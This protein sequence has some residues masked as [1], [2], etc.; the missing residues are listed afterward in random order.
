M[1]PK[2]GRPA[3]GALASYSSEIR[4]KIY[5]LRHNNSGWGAITIL[6]ELEHVLHYPSQQ[7]P[8]VDSVHRYLKECGFV[9]PKTP[10]SD[11][12]EVSIPPV[13]S[14]HDLW[15]MDAQGAVFVK[16]V[17]YVSMINIKDSKSKAYIMSFPVQ[18]KSKMSQPKTAHY[19]WTLRLA[20]E[21]FGLPKAM[22]V[23]KDS[24]FKDN[25]SKSPFPSVV[26]L[27][28][29]GLGIELS[30]INVAPPAKQAMVER[31]HQTLDKQVFQGKTYK[32]WHELFLNT[33]KRRFILNEKYP[34]RS[35]GKRAPF[36]VYPDVLNTQRPY[37]VEQEK[38]LLNLDLVEKHLEQYT[39]Y[40]K[41]S[42]VRT[43]SLKGIYYL[44][45]AEPKN[46]VQIKFYAISK[47]L[48]FR[49]VNEQILKE[50]ITENFAKN[51]LQSQSTSELLSMRKKI[52]KNKDFPL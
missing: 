52:L 7:L 36:E 18:V 10:K 19:L 40:R 9:K 6:V 13:K 48:I 37:F 35:L 5:E 33:N 41:V 47:K 23:D 15:E 49:D 39:W 51:L 11:A 21:Q 12:P 32:N 14:C 50:L 8:S 45:G 28:L 17:G 38:T 25:T 34:C 44:K 3:L 1:S 31:S 24:V 46:Y 20:F 22:Q 30:F 4:D 16:G 43:I 26:K 2:Q 29:T 27:F 42:S